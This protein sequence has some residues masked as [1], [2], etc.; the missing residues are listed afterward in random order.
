[1]QQLL[2]RGADVDARALDGATA[3]HFACHFGA[4]DALR[5]LLKV[6]PDVDAQCNSGVTPLMEACLKGHLEAATLLIDYGADPDLINNAGETALH[7]A[8]WRVAQDAVPPAAGARYA[9][10]IR[11]IE[12]HLAL[13]AM[14]RGGGDV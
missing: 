9:P 13:V 11:Q 4:N 14:L 5:G 1:M 7:F 8:E 6:R 10:G 3:L 12:E 2:A